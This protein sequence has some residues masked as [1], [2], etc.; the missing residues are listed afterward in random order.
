MNK[1]HC[2]SSPCSDGTVANSIFSVAIKGTKVFLLL[3]A[4][5]AVVLCLY[6]L[7]LIITVLCK[8]VFLILSSLI[9]LCLH[10]NISL[11]SSMAFLIA[12]TL[13]MHLF[14]IVTCIL[15]C[16]TKITA[17]FSLLAERPHCRAML[18]VRRI[19]CIALPIIVSILLFEIIQWTA[20]KRLHVLERLAGMDKC[21]D[22]SCK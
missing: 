8:I 13:C 3:E 15:L 11:P 14:P 19:I 1:C 2:V 9:N 4:V 5:L 20:K 22:D 7:F 16:Y 17:K 6:N 18:S 21:V 12:A 10:S